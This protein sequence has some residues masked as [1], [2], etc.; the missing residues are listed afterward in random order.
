MARNHETK[1]RLRAHDRRQLIEE[2][3]S[4]LFAERGYGATTLEQVASAAGVTR[5]L[6]YKHFSSKKELHLTLL[7]KHRDALLAR[8][9]HGLGDRG[10]LADRIPRVTDSWFQYVEENPFA[11]SM[12]FRDTTG[13]PEIQAFYR[14]MQG[15]ARSAL[16]ALIRDE[17]ELELPEERI[18][19]TAEFFR[20]AMTGLALWWAEHPAVPRALV[21]DIVV[22]AV[23]D[24]LQLEVNGE[25]SF[26]LPDEGER[27]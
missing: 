8:L 4:K 22:R 11:W 26:S 10:S 25:A 7:A 20:S 16:A 15:T 21:V 24:G 3:A 18:E 1:R 27:A 9:A 14:E 12:L 6:L 19:P 2:A 17:P 5:P 23:S 13:D